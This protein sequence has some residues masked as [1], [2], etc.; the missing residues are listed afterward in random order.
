ML[1]MDCKLWFSE[2][3]RDTISLNLVLLTVRLCEGRFKNPMYSRG[4]QIPGR[5][6]CGGESRNHDCWLQF[7]PVCDNFQCLFNSVLYLYKQYFHQMISSNS[8]NDWWPSPRYMWDRNGDR[9]KKKLWWQGGFPY[10][11]DN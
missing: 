8:K 2:S 3:Y 11:S 4:N 6:P 5:L 9:T 1:D 10:D 7:T